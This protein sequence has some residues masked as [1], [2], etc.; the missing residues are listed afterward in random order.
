M[1]IRRDIIIDAFLD[2]IN[3]EFLITRRKS[4]ES[5]ETI[6]NPHYFEQG[7]FVSLDYIDRYNNIFYTTTQSGTDPKDSYHTIKVAYTYNEYK[8]FHDKWM[9]FRNRTTVGEKNLNSPHIEVK[10]RNSKFF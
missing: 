6:F 4:K 10:F 2:C 7:K 3:N 8:P 5:G 1:N 9:K